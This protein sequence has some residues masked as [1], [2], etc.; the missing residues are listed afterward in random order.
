MFRIDEL[1]TF[2]QRVTLIV[3]H[4]ANAVKAEIVSTLGRQN[5]ID[6]EVSKIM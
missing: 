4:L 2:E 6:L 1:M 3:G 5:N